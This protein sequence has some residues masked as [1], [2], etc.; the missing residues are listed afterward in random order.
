[1]IQHNSH[2]DRDGN[3]YVIVVLDE[4]ERDLVAELQKFADTAA[5]WTEFANYYARRVGKFYEARGLSRR[6]VVEM[7]VWKIAQDIRARLQ[8]DAG[9]ARGAD[10]RT[11]LESLILS[12]FGSHREFCEATGISADMLSHVL[13]RR[14]NFGINK[15]AEALSKIGYAI[16]IAPLPSANASE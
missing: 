12:K 11:E 13:A 8:I 10:Y 15:L 4:E 16:H 6:E 5:N 3:R 7:P 2:V 9:K 1:M 14:K